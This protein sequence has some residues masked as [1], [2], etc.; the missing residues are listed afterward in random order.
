[1]SAPSPA[2]TAALRTLAASGFDVF[3][4]QLDR[5]GVQAPLF[6]PEADPADALRVVL[7]TDVEELRAALPDPAKRRRPARRRGRR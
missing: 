4:T 1:M 7:S 3:V 6:P 2:L 5:V